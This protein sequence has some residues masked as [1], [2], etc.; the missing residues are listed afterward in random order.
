MTQ[1]QG[2]KLGAAA[3]VAL[4]LAFSPIAAMAE[5]LTF[6]QVGGFTLGSAQS[7]ACPVPGASGCVGGVEFFGATGFNADASSP[8]AGSPT[9][10]QIGWGVGSQTPPTLF[11]N[12]PTFAAAPNNTVVTT[13][14]VSGQPPFPG[15]PADF[16]VN[17]ATGAGYRSALDLD[18]FSGQL[19]I[20]DPNFTPISSLQHY[21][22][23]IGQTANVLSQVDIDT[24]LTLDTIPP[25]GTPPG[26]TDPGFVQLGFQETLNAGPCQAGTGGTP[27]ADIFSFQAI[28]FAPVIFHIGDRTF[29]AEFNLSF[30]NLT[31]NEGPGALIQTNGATPCIDTTHVCT[32][33]NAISEAII[34][35]RVTEIFVPAPASL[36]LLGFGLSGL[37][38]ARWLRR[39]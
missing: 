19:T 29:L 23:T 31:T 38:A 9:Y 25:T 33:E 10:G 15:Q 37:G 28:T 32:A 13:S 30:P 5:N 16:P 34:G 3:A 20:G 8:N 24:L 14:P 22:R 39:K 2:W 26:N 7:A 27:C 36:L 12:D 21:N 11:P 1:K 35:I 6:T 17:P 4:G 18:V